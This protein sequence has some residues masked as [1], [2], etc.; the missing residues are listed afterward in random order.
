MLITYGDEGYGESKR[1]TQPRQM[2][3]VQRLTLM[4]NQTIKTIAELEEQLERER[5]KLKKV[6]KDIQTYCNRELQGKHSNRPQPVSK[7]ESI[8]EYFNVG[9]PENIIA[10]TAGTSLS[11]VYKILSVYRKEKGIKPNE[12]S[13]RTQQ[14]ILSLLSMG[15]KDKEVALQI[16]VSP[17]YVNQIKKKF[18][19]DRRG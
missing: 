14:R 1:P 18:E 17:Q 6:E 9:M 3:E 13:L 8:I 15:L 16:G 5:N 11:Y 10:A 7:K 12:K 19:N 4:K 2:N